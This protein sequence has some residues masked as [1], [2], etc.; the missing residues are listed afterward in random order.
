[1]YMY[2]SKLTYYYMHIM[3]AGPSAEPSAPRGERPAPA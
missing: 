3:Y 1:M 2:I